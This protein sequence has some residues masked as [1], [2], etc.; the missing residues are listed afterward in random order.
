MLLRRLDVLERL[1]PGS[2][3]Y[4]SR[5]DASW[6]LSQDIVAHLKDVFQ[7][8][9]LLLVLS[10]QVVDAVVD[11][12]LDGRHARV[13][14]SALTLVTTTKRRVLGSSLM[15]KLFITLHL[16]MLYNILVIKAYYLLNRIFSLKT[17][18][19][20]KLFLIQITRK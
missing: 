4:N 5:S 16:K 20:L 13:H 10:D 11:G 2:L 15:E 3:N 17:L 9:R 12:L 1:E 8:L 6:P 19:N 7:M 18:K 14:W